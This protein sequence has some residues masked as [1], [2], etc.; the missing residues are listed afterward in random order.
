MAMVRQNDPDVERYCFRGLHPDIFVGTASDRYAGWIGQIYSEELYKDRI[1][2]RAHK[3]G[4][5]SFRE[6]VLPVD[7]L[8]EYFAHFSVLEIDYTF[9]QLLLDPSGA[10]TQS[11]HVL[12]SY[13]EH[14]ANG[15]SV[16]LKV[17][18]AIFAQKIRRGSH[19]LPNETY[20]NPEIFTHRFYQPATELMGPHLKGFI[21]EQEYQ[22][23]DERLPATELA[24]AL[25]EF[26]GAIPDDHRYHVELRTESYLVKAMFTVF[27]D[28]G[29][30]QVFSHWTWLPPL[31]KQF[32]KSAGRFFNSGQQ[33][34]IRLMTPLG[35]RYEEAYA[36]AFPF[37]HLVEGMLQPRM[38]DETAELMREGTRQNVSVN[39]IINNRAGGNAPRIA[40]LVA[41][42]FLSK[43]AAAIGCPP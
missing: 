13:R 7:S 20:L 10:P 23:K 14:M 36:Q 1:I 26:F 18:Q 6:T 37:N 34:I 16:I 29:I 32:G 9:Y 42:R 43:E 41:E 12:K 17:P 31:L 2:A 25:A 8:K 3:V 19:H 24:A 27:E 30:G 40:Q 21:F 28:L 5:R 4:G 22:R 11:F 39:V 38:V 35:T 15:D 33:A